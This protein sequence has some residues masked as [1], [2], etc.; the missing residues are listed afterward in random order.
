MIDYM[1]NMQKRITEEELLSIPSE[2]EGSI[3]TGGYVKVLQ[4]WYRL[5]YRSRGNGSVVTESIIPVGHYV[6]FK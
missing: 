5:T 2:K 4:C 1:T 3:C 6:G